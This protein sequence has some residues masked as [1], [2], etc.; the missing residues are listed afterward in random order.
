[1][2][3]LEGE[4]IFFCRAATCG[5]RQRLD[6]DLLLIFHSFNSGSTLAS[7]GRGHLFLYGDYV[8][9]KLYE[10]HRQPLY[11]G[12][13]KIALLKRDSLRGIRTIIMVA[14]QHRASCER[15]CSVKMNE[16]HILRQQKIITTLDCDLKNSYHDQRQHLCFYVSCLSVFMN[17]KHEL[18]L[19]R[20]VKMR[21]DEDYENKH[22]PTWKWK[23]ILLVLKIPILLSRALNME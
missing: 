11:C 1:M 12:C 3:W 5:S 18:N 16:F 6:V 23:H 20:I 2:L 19:I 14:E 15:T 4:A 9:Q 21:S 7:P 8:M 13:K 17:A 22:F 10:R